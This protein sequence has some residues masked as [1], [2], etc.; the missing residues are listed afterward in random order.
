MGYSFF[1]LSMLAFT[2]CSEETVQ[3]GSPSVAQTLDTTSDLTYGTNLFISGIDTLSSQLIPLNVDGPVEVKNH[4]G[5]VSFDCVDDGGK[6][7][8]RPKMLQ[9]MR[10]ATV[11]DSVT[12]SVPGNS[13]LSKELL[14]SVRSNGMTP[15]QPQTTITRSAN[16]LPTSFLTPYS[17]PQSSVQRLPGQK[18]S[19][20][21]CC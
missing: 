1:A 8:L 19:I 3:N 11:L 18:F 21:I 20:L 13:S 15:V 2:A 6:Y 14:V 16:V 9:S 4:G 7:Y 10:G 17:L 5:I 12:I